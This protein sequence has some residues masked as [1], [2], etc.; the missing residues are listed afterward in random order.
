MYLDHPAFGVSFLAVMLAGAGLAA[1]A[2]TSFELEEDLSVRDGSWATATETALD[3]TF[4]LKDPSVKAWTTLEYHLTGW[5]L[6]G[7][8]VGDEGWLFTTEEFHVHPDGALARERKL[9][10]I[11]RV[12]D[13]LAEHDAV[14]VVAVIPAKARIE[15]RQLGRYTVPAE[16]HAVYDTFRAEISA[17]GVLAPDLADALTAGAEKTFCF[18][19]THWTPQGA[20]VAAQALALAIRQRHPSASWDTVHWDRPSASF[21]H[22]GDLLSYLPLLHPLPP[23]TLVGY[24]LEEVD[25]GGLGLFDE[26]SY[27]V[28]VTGSSYTAQK[29]W[30]FADSLA[31]ALGVRVVDASEEGGG[32]IVPMLE[33]L[34][35]KAFTEQPPE[36]VVWEMPERFLGVRYAL[37]GP[38]AEG[39]PE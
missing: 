4:L 5:G 11:E 9:L 7:V 6:D 17:R 16:K 8:L 20:R 21:Q 35:D 15:Q 38:L 25:G 2:G 37:E 26:I 1:H 10:L 39:L 34:E 23:E 19:D 22:E 29:Q 33:Y 18:T 28:A 30:G 27:T 3:D 12:R 24:G 13:R 14:L 32:P 31:E 36:V